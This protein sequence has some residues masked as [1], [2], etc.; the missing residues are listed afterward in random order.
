MIKIEDLLS[1]VEFKRYQ[2][3]VRVTYRPSTTV[4]DISD[5]LRAIPG[6]LTIVQVDH[7]YQK[8]FAI[9]KAKILST[10]EPKVAYNNC[11][12]QNSRDIKNRSG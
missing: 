7:D 5:F 9:L 11:S 1:E 4:N 2:A 6:V 8:R 10:K 12:I 3:V